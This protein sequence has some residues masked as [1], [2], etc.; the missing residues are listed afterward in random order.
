MKPITGTHGAPIIG[1]GNVDIKDGQ[2]LVTVLL[3]GDPLGDKDKFSDD[4]IDH[5][6]AFVRER[7]S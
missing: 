6:Q 4:M 2:I 3:N 7:M 5:I 1:T